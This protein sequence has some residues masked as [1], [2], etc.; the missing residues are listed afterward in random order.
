MIP[1]SVVERFQTLHR[2][3]KF[4][5]ILKE[6]GIIDEKEFYDLMNRIYKRFGD[7]IDL[8]NQ[9]NLNVEKE[10]E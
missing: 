3:H 10:N 4:M 1:E 2:Y 6:N 9:M 7:P 8:F 5:T